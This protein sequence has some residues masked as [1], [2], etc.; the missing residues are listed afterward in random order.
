M[1]EAG[2]KAK[3]KI[4]KALARPTSATREVF[5]TTTTKRK[6]SVMTKTN[7][8]KGFNQGSA[9]AIRA[10]L[11]TNPCT[12]PERPNTTNKAEDPL[13]LEK[14]FRNR[15]DK[16]AQTY[17]KVTSNKK[18]NTSHRVIDICRIKHMNERS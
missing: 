6:I 18:K 15:P 10:K 3:H 5:T 7:A 2:I 12:K 13:L 16:A 14:K 8:A 17:P 11:S 9:V 4:Q 1:A